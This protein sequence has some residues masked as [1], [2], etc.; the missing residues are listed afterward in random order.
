M[1][2]VSLLQLCFE[3]CEHDACRRNCRPHDVMRHQS[4]IPI[5]PLHSAPSYTLDCTLSR[6]TECV[7]ALHW[8]VHYSLCTSKKREIIHPTTE[9]A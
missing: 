1:V 5:T 7:R 2:A 8:A 9:P 3:V 6:S 4:I